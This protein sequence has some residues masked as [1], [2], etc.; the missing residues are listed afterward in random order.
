M[1]YLR[2]FIEN[3]HTPEVYFKNLVIEEKE[4][5]NLRLWVLRCMLGLNEEEMAKKLKIPLKK[6][7]KY[8]KSGEKV[9]EKVLQKISR[10]FGISL[11]WLKC[12]DSR[13]FP[14]IKS[15]R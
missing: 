2:K 10:E 8:E 1:E 14:E 9:P 4:N 12:K 7:K 3:I 11:K 5:T 6:Y 13:W 15:L